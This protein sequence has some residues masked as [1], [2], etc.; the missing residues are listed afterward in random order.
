[1]NL[2]TFLKK[3]VA[4]N[5]DHTSCDNCLTLESE[6]FYLKQ[7]I[8]I[9]E[10]IVNTSQV[11]AEMNQTLL[12]NHDQSL[13]QTNNTHGIDA[14][15]Q[16]DCLSSSTVIQDGI[17]DVPKSFLLIDSTGNVEG[18]DSIFSLCDNGNEISPAISSV[19]LS[20]HNISVSSVSSAA[21]VT[22]H[23]TLESASPVTIIDECPFQKF[24]LE[25]LLRE[26]NFTHAFKN[27]KAVYLGEHPH[28]YKGGVHAANTVP[29]GSY[30]AILCSY[31][32]VP[33]PDYMFNSVLV[34]L[35]KMVTVSYPHILIQRSV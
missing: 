19:Y 27:R 34:N 18:P 9:L 25:T 6:N 14:E 22:L 23:D 13:N 16:T 7:K 26:L 5:I 1:M 31:L 29:Q 24:S 35:Y 2:D 4:S 12:S 28:G 15:V 33:L 3:L 32:E 10:D 30:L 20:S 11:I 21:T 17:F 8:K